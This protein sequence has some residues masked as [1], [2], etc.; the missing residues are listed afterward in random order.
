M[1]D[2]ICVSNKF[3][4]KAEVCNKLFLTDYKGSPEM[5]WFKPN[6]FDGTP[7]ED[8]KVWFPVLDKGKTSWID[9]LVNNGEE[10]I[11]KND[12]ENGKAEI[13]QKNITFTKIGDKYS[14][15][16]IFKLASKDADGTEHWKR[17]C[18]KCVI[19]AKLT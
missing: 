17:I 18:D 15:A 2:N 5:S 3:N 11:S 1:S 13:G 6:T 8:Y 9:E 12:S 19:F 7:L 14:Y 4:S 10:I 16:G